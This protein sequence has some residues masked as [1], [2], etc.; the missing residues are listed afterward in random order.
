MFTIA[1]MAAL[2]A[3]GNAADCFWRCNVGSCGCSAGYYGGGYGG[4]GY[5]GGY[6]GGGGYGGGYGGGGYGG[7]YAGW[8]GPGQAAPMPPPPPI[9][10]FVPVA[11]ADQPAA[12]STPCGAA[13]GTQNQPE[14]LLP[15][16]KVEGQTAR[17][18]IVVDVP[19]NAKLYIADNLVASAQEG[20]R[21]ER[22]A[23]PRDRNI[24]TTF[25][26]R[27]SAMGKP[28]PT[29]GGLSC[30]QAKKPGRLSPGWMMRYW[31]QRREA[32]WGLDH[33]EFSE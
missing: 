9:Y 11:P 14:P 17:A 7:G 21:S 8:A 18:T 6:N 30:K 23:C 19:A 5:G 31:Q 13:P 26:R 20:A 4:G 2:T 22:R 27:W 15:P 10:I 32:M 29:P 25:A 16:R 33:N 1:L 3:S 12:Y 28:T 24:T